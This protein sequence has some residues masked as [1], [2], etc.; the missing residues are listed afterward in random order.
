MILSSDNL[1]KETLDGQSR[2]WGAG[3]GV[4]GR[5]WLLRTMYNFWSQEMFTVVVVDTQPYTFAK[6]HQSIPLKLP[7]FILYQ[8][9]LNK[10]D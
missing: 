1:E 10:A 4:G 3:R 9:Y 6:T 2:S 5:G 8:S 7:N